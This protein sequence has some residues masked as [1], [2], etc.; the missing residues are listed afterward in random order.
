MQAA[1]PPRRMR[2]GGGRGRLL[3]WEERCLD[4]PRESAKALAGS[5]LRCGDWGCRRKG[6]ERAETGRPWSFRD[7]SGGRKP[8][9]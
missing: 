1:A 5:N 8:P 4:G 6:V 3:G 2:A 7:G 9:D